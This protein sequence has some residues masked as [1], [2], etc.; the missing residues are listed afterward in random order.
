MPEITDILDRLATQK[1]ASPYG[2]LST[3]RYQ[4]YVDGAHYCGD[5]LW[6][7]ARNWLQP[8]WSTKV[9]ATEVVKGLY[10]S[11]LA[12]VFNKRALDEMGITHVINMVPG[13]LPAFPNSYKYLNLP[14]RDVAT[15]NI[16]QYFPETTQTIKDALANGGKVIVHCSCGVSRSASVVIAYLITERSMSA[17][18]AYEYLKHKRPVVEPNPGFIKQLDLL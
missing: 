15:E 2:V 16:A 3:Y 1:T 13:V 10:I 14:L 6:G 12:T 5:W 4:D 18:D 7:T 9:D 8:M 11:D 17:K